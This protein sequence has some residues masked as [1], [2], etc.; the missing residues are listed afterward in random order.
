MR[1]IPTD[2]VMKNMINLE[3]PSFVVLTG[4]MISG[5]IGEGINGW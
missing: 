3:D 5:W 4:D 2:F 1:D